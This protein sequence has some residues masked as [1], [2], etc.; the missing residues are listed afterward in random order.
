MFVDRTRFEAH[1]GRGGD[2]VISFRHEACAPRGGPDGGDGGDGG[3]V[4]VVARQS[5]P[6]L[7]DVAHRPAYRAED[8]RRGRSRNMAGRKGEDLV[9]E[10]PRGT[11]DLDAVTGTTVADLTDEGAE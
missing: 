6:T 7:A 10:V 5:R 8:G 1:A 2:G 3:S 9:V 11:L 4:I